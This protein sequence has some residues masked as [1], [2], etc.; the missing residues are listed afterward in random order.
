MSSNSHPISRCRLLVTAGV[1]GAA[2]T[3]GL[4]RPGRALANSG[5][6][7]YQPSW[8]S[9]D[10]HPPTPEWFQDAKFGIYYHWGV[11]SVPAFSNEWY[12]RNMHDPG[13]IENQH[14]IAT[15]GDPSA[16]PYHFFMLGAD[17]KAGN[18]TKVQPKL[19]ADGGNWDPNARATLFKNAGA[20]FAGPVAEHH[21]GYSMWNSQVNEWNSVK[22]GPGLDQRWELQDAGNGRYHIVNR[23]TGTALDGMGQHGD[24]LRHRHV[25]G[26]RQHQQRVHDHR[27][28]TQTASTPF[29][30]GG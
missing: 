6:Q 10:Q 14:H 22:T 11:F 29:G 5:P 4:L 19:V 20:K 9:V 3:A 17:D 12:P 8:A 21:D 26:Q 24:R 28:L 2:A 23:G 1:T 15:Y 18:F 30:K 16:W 13:S 7:N 27:S 25:G